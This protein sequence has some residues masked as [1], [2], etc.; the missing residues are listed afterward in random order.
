MYQVSLLRREKS[1]NE[2]VTIYFENFDQITYSI[3][4]IANTQYVTGGMT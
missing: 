4:S 1:C 3:P 2:G